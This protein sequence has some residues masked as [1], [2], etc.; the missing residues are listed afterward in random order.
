MDIVE[1]G[2]DESWALT[3]E[4]YQGDA[5][6]LVGILPASLNVPGCGDSL[7]IVRPNNRVAHGFFIDLDTGK[8]ESQRGPPIQGNSSAV[9]GIQPRLR[10]RSIL[11]ERLSISYQPWP[12]PWLRVAT[13]D[14]P[15]QSLSF[16]TEIP[17]QKY[18]FCV[19]HYSTATIK[20]T[21]QETDQ[22]VNKAAKK[23]SLS[24][25][26][27]EPAF[28]DA[29]VICQGTEFP[30]H[31]AVLTLASPVFAATFQGGMQEAHEARLQ[32]VDASVDAA[33]ALLRYIY[34]DELEPSLAMLVMPLAHRYQLDTLIIRCG[35]EMLK[36]VAPDNVAQMIRILRPLQ[37]DAAV[38]FVWQNMLQKLRT[39]ESLL[40][41]TLNGL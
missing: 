5:T 41:P 38:Q 14:A 20:I 33:K 8:L 2:D 26:W 23:A 11:W 10:D 29:V 6:I 7:D 27:E 4:E 25:M 35:E 18:V 30:V 1:F 15:L 16:R 37:E 19:L 34:T 36:L 13:D 3:L 17:A 39:E 28:T 9:F 40:E 31:R 24:R 22:R 21:L 32:I 12:R